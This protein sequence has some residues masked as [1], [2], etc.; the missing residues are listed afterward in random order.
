MASCSLVMLSP[1][2]ASIQ[3]GIPLIPEGIP[4]SQLLCFKKLVVP[5]LYRYCKLVD[6]I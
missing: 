4:N 6:S 2:I 1:N 3:A 5:L